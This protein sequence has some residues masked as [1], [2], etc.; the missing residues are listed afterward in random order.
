MPEN[1]YHPSNASVKGN[2][3]YEIS[4][5]IVR[6]ILF[7][8]LQMVFCAIVMKVLFFIQRCECRCDNGEEHAISRDIPFKHDIRFI[9]KYFQKWKHLKNSQK[10]V[11]GIRDKVL[12]KRAVS[13]LRN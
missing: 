2:F 7:I 6:S 3:L 11:Q 1:L 5:S 12:T 4:K 9:N 8:P 13:V 10:H